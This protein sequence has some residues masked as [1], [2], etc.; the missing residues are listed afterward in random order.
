M[1]NCDLASLAS[2]PASYPME[3]IQGKNQLVGVG[4]VLETR[5][6]CQHNGVHANNVLAEWLVEE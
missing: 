6:C 3:T 2:S 1:K 5:K 4:G